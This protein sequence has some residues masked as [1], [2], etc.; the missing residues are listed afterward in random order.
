MDKIGTDLSKKQIGEVIQ[1]FNPHMDDYLYIMDLQK[2][3]Y[4]I[5]KHAVDRFLLPSEH[6]HD[7][8]KVHLQFVYEEDRAHLSEDLNLIKSGQKN[9]HNLHYR[10]LDRSGTPVWI[11]CRGRVLDDENGTPRY[12]IG[13]INETG[14]KQRA[15]NISG[16]LG[17]SE[18]SAYLTSLDNS[19]T[20]GYLM[21]IGIDDFS[22]IN[23]TYGTTYGD[24]VLKHVA[25]CIYQSLTSS[26]RLFHLVGDEYMVVDLAE[27]TAE[28][29][30]ALYRT[31][32]KKIS[33][34][35]DA[36]KYKSVITISAGVI[37]ADKLNGAYEDFLRLS[38]FTLKCAKDTG[39]N[40]CS[41][42][43]E[44]DYQRFLRKRRITMALH[45][46]VDNGFKGF[47]AY[48]Q[49][50]VD[51][52]TYRLLGAESLMRFSIAS[53]DGQEPERISPVEFIPILEETGLILPAGRWILNEAVAM[54][55]KMQKTI[56]G[57]RINVN[58]SYIQVIK[59][60][61]LNDILAAIN[62]YALPP[63][64]IG[65]EVTE[66]G[67]LDSNAHFLQ[68]W[69]GLKEHGITLIIDDFGTGY[70]NLHCLSD[71][72]PTYIKL[73]RD[74]TNKAMQNLYDHELMIKI[75]EMAH[76]LHLQI[77]VE[78]VERSEDLDDIRQIHAD[79]IQGYLFGKPCCKADFYEKFV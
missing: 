4:I 58:I 70:S 33:A 54:C 25:D 56:P 50:I 75:I 42:F 22:S 23:S 63:E 69:N 65:I 66:S 43:R 7:A 71:L 21:R 62:K 14:N 77:C 24:Y 47:E 26:Q 37:E 44:E 36:E 18:L 53:K 2:D 5:S 61:I 55:S 3:D 13:C 8:M 39:K 19:I 6:F 45:H 57:F 76:S 67:Y 64:C 10:W 73:D 68:L 1:L 79:Y 35:I 34:F 28:D 78:G 15:D 51:C 74:F 27:H 16:L 12:L 41:I 46:A 9:S 31:I 20:T 52:E 29:A 17:E 49:P 30:M 32:Q 11:N 48:Y 40:Q 59:S 38:E 60:S 72:N